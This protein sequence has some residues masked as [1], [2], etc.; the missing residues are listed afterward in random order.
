MNGKLRISCLVLLLASSMTA[1]S[2]INARPSP[3]SLQA[4]SAHSADPAVEFV[5]AEE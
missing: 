1:S 5:G 3:V 2:G 4:Q